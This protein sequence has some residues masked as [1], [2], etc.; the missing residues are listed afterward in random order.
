MIIVIATIMKH[1]KDP[2]F[3]AIYQKENKYKTDST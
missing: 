3:I 2:L 1:V